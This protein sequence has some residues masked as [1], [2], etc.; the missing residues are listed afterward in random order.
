MS[1]KHCTRLAVL[2]ILWGASLSAAHAQDARAGAPAAA[3]Q[4]RTVE[5]LTGPAAKAIRVQIKKQRLLAPDL[6]RTFYGDATG[7]GTKDAISF[8]YSPIEGAASGGALDV[9]VWREN[10]GSYVLNRTAKTDDVFGQDPRDVKFA[11]GTITV[12]TT[13]PKPNDPH[14]CPTGIRTYSIA[15]K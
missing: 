7:Q 3:S 14:C 8:V 13:V 9:W 2:G 11:P 6:V 15:I 10:N 1:A 5:G 4:A 12:T